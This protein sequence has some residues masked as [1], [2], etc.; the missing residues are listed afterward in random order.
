MSEDSITVVGEAPGVH[1]VWLWQNVFVISWYGKSSAES[2]RALGPITDRIYTQVSYE[3]FSYVHLIANKLELPDAATRTA[4][5]DLTHE[6]GPRTACVAVIVSGTGF[7]ASAIR[8]FVTGIRVLAPRGFDLR[9]HAA[10]PELGEWLPE[11]HERKTG[12]KLE[13]SELIRQIER[14]QL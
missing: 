1:R 6:H 11:E 4:L 3:K 9:M 13:P 7:W 8:S 2:A 10:I 14:T 5:L 12:V